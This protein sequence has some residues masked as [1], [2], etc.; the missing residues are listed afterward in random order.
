MK[1]MVYSGLLKIYGTVRYEQYDDNQCSEG[2]VLSI[3]VMDV[4][5]VLNFAVILCA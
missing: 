3:A 1:L 2:K 4:E 5:T